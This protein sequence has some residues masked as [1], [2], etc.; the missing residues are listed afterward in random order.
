[1]RQRDDEMVARHLQVA[2]ELLEQA[3]AIAM[4]DG[5]VVSASTPRFHDPINIAIDHLD[6]GLKRIEE[7][8]YYGATHEECTELKKYIDDIR[9]TLVGTMEA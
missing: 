6:E 2:A 5:H 7:A 4:R 8:I 3:K 1:M 9:A